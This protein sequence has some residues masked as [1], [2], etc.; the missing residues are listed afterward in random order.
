MIEVN[1]KRYYDTDKILKKLLELYQ[2]NSKEQK[3]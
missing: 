3:K 1:G 2:Q